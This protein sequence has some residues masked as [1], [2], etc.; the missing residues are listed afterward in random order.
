MLNSVKST[1]IWTRKKGCE[2][3]FE[4][5]TVS[6]SLLGKYHSDRESP[7]LDYTRDQWT[8]CRRDHPS[9]DWLGSLEDERMMWVMSWLQSQLTWADKVEL[10]GLRGLTTGVADQVHGVVHVGHPVLVLA[11]HQTGD[12][13]YH[14]RVKSWH[15]GVGAGPVTTARSDAC[16]IFIFLSPN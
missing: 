6:P 2:E 10:F 14:E 15:H 9:R 8:A 3:M 12:H 11:G 4:M 5:K 16:S 7:V 1:R 13:T